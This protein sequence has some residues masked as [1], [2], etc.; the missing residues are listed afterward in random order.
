[1]IIAMVVVLPAPLPPSNPVMLPRGSE[2]EIPSTA[3]VCL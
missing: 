1:M 3:R 2:K